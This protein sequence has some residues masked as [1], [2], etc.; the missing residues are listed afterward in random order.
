V[1]ANSL[2]SED[3]SIDKDGSQNIAAKPQPNKT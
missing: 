3:E 2:V 1:N